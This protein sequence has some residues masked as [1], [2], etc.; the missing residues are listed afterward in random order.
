MQFSE[1][2]RRLKKLNPRL[3]IIPGP[4][5]AWGLYVPTGTYDPESHGEGLRW[6]AGMS[7]PKFAGPNLPKR[8]FIMPTER[9]KGKPEF[10]RGW[11]GTV[12]QLVSTGAIRR[13][14]ALHEFS[15]E[16]VS[17]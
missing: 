8:D 6:V 15:Y 1:F 9:T 4:N 17:L 5:K 16:L 3:R 10:M 13:S 7:S 12:K 14:E 11:K 2:Q